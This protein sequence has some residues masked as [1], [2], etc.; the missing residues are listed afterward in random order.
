MNFVGSSPLKKKDLNTLG[1]FSEE[2]QMMFADDGFQMPLDDN[3]HGDFDNDLK[4]SSKE[5]IL[6]K[7]N[8]KNERNEKLNNM[9]SLRMYDTAGLD[10]IDESRSSPLKIFK[11][12]S[13]PAENSLY[14]MDMTMSLEA[15]F[16]FCKDHPLLKEIYECVLN[17]DDFVEQLPHKVLDDTYELLN[18]EE[19]NFINGFNA[20]GVIFLLKKLMD[21]YEINLSI[22]NNFNVFSGLIQSSEP[23]S[24]IINSVDKN[25]NPYFVNV[26]KVLTLYDLHFLCTNFNDS[27]LVIRFN[28]PNFHSFSELKKDKGLLNLVVKNLKELIEQ[29]LAQ[30]FK[31]QFFENKILVVLNKLSK[32]Q[33][34]LLIECHLPFLQKGFLFDVIDCLSEA[35]SNKYKQGFDQVTCHKIFRYCHMKCDDID[36]WGYKKFKDNMFIEEQQR[37]G[38]PYFKPSG[39]W[40]RFG[41]NVTSYFQTDCET[42]WFSNDNNSKEWAVCYCNIG[43]KQKLS[44]IEREVYKELYSASE[45]GNHNKKCG[46]GVLA[47]F[48]LNWLENLNEGS[49][50][51]GSSSLGGSSWKKDEKDV[52]FFKLQSLDFM[53]AEF[54]SYEYCL[55][56]QC[57]VNPSKI[58]FPNKF[59]RKVFIVN[60]PNDIRPYGILIKKME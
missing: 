40:I 34:L 35:L 22:E 17:E 37:G 26:P 9:K 41:F 24:N 51:K 59:G 19:T 54:K 27:I 7:T 58:L 20:L 29:N 56:L 25:K 11:Y 16:E 46:F 30:N 13:K 33:K 53:D 18:H 47:T 36:L 52:D 60:D 44:T 14:E 6:P 1:E 32:S 48:D 3:I 42:D 55:A 4:L 15:N 2:D 39:G 12:L 5:F 10:K 57:R 31:Q 43:L 8:E 28:E 50:F 45:E 23:I 38:L 21:S 49:K